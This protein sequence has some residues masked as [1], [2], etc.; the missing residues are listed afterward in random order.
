MFTLTLSADEITAIG[1]ALAEGPY[2]VVAPVLA[3][4]Q[5]QINDQQKAP[6][7]ETVKPEVIG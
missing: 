7:S 3:N 4:I 2:K 5:Q 6:A 1:N